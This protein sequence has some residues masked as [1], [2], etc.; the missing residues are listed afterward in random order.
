MKAQ[1]KWVYYGGEVYGINTGWRLTVVEV[2]RKWVYLQVAGK[3]RHKILR[4]VYEAMGKR[5]V[6]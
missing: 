1:R 3:R 6:A 5:E 4:S 2:G